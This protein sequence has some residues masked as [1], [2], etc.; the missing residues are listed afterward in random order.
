MLRTLVCVGCMVAA[1]PTWAATVC[2]VDFQEAV[3]DTEEGKSAQT[4]IDTMYSAR[5][6]ELERMQTD[7]EKAI[8][9][10][11]GRAMILSEQARGEEEQKLSL[12]QRTFEQTYMQY[13]QEMQQTYAGLLGDLDLKIRAV[14][15]EV[16]KSKGCSVVLDSQVVVFADSSITDISGDL[17]AR[18]NSAHPNK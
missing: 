8:T 6:S 13:Q 11:N 14:A 3:T 18:Y 17:V 1:T 5:K 4:K 16:G 9:D 7:L 2:T 10:F 15:G 12:K